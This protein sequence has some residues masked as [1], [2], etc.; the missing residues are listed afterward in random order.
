MDKQE[1]IY[2]FELDNCQYFIDLSKILN[3]KRFGDSHL[4][5][6]GLQFTITFQLFSKPVEYYGPEESNIVFL[7]LIHAWN[8]YKNNV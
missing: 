7:N 5:Y 4:F 3:I 2:S 8:R 6:Y 1:A